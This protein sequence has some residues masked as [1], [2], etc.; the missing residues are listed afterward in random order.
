MQI[1]ELF[2]YRTNE[3]EEIKKKYKSYGKNRNYEQT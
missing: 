3:K 2:K 1:T